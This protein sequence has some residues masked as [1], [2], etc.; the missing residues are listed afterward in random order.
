MEAFIEDVGT[1][2]GR[3][4]KRLEKR[5]YTALPEEATKTAFVLPFI[6]MMGYDTRDIDEVFP[7]YTAD[8]GSMKGK[9]VDYALMHDDRLSIIIECKPYGTR[10]RGQP[11]QQLAQYFASTSAQF[12]ILT[13][14]VEYLFY[15]ANDAENVMDATP[16]FVFHML[17]HTEQD[18]QTLYTYHRDVFDVQ[19]AMGVA[20]RA[21]RRTELAKSL[22]GLLDDPTDDFVRFLAKTV[23][24]GQM[25]KNVMDQFAPIVREVCR[26]VVD[27]KVE[28]RLSDALASKQKVQ[29]SDEVHVEVVEPSENAMQ[30]YDL[31]S[32]GYTL[33]ETA[34][35]MGKSPNTVKTYVGSTNF[36]NNPLKL[37]AC[38]WDQDGQVTDYQWEDVVIQNGGG[39]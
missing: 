6:E 22:D 36:P 30:A 21:R 7:E 39:D 20:L 26:S 18:V 27:D 17:D 12:G 28:R 25:H 10:L 24:T 3:F 23:Y 13:D 4:R 16:S 14:G 9:K 2:Q 8:F 29:V 37:R 19:A 11:A 1:R 32:G 15:T 5:D 38:A 33:L 34:K 35:E 31:I